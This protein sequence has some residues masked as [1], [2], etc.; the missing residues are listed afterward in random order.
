MTRIVIALSLAAASLLGPVVLAQGARGTIAGI[1]TDNEGPVHTAD[2]E[3]TNKAT[4][5]VYPARTD[6]RGRYSISVPPGTYDVAVLPLGFR[7]ERKAEDNKVVEAGRTLSLDFALTR[8]NDAVVGDDAAFLALRRKY[9]D[10]TGPMPRAS[11]GTPDLSGVWNANVDPNPAPPPL[12][13]WAE[14]EWKQRQANDFKDLPSSF[15]LPEDPSWSTPI[16]QKIVQTP[17]LIV[18]LNEGTPGFRQIFLDG[19]PHPKDPDPTW[20][21]HAIGRWEGDTLVVETVGF[22][23]K[24][25]LLPEGFP[26]TDQMRMIE[27]YRRLDLGNMTREVSIIDPGAFTKPLE[28]RIAWQLTPGEDLLESICTENNKFLEN[29]SSK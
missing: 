7:T 11:D 1:V 27:R 8:G 26:H 21:G 13:P 16:L 20:Q 15:C 28:R 2:V 18:M 23:D 5:T 10:V 19:R 24:S 25:W 17:T 22:N 6:V 9:I 29:I 4:S 12:L 14:K 3:A